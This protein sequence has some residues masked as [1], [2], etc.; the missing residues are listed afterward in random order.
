MAEVNLEI[1]VKMDYQAVQVPQDIL[2][3]T[4]NQV[5]PVPQVR[6]CHSGALKQNVFWSVGLPGLMGINGAPGYSGA[7]GSKGLPVGN[8]DRAGLIHLFVCRVYLAHRVIQD[9]PDD[10]ESRVHQVRGH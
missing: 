6:S 10:V 5:S 3:K 8:F 2:V 9:F 1:V 4:E 7:A